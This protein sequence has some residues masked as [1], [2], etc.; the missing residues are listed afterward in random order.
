M[1][2]IGVFKTRKSSPDKIKKQ[3]QDEQNFIVISG[4]M[5]DLVRPVTQIGDGTWRNP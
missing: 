1:R 4:S 2:I 3:H 5:T